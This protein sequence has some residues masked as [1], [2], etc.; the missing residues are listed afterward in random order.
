MQLVKSRRCCVYVYVQH[1]IYVYAINVYAIHVAPPKKTSVPITS[2]S[3]ATAPAIGLSFFS[4][5]MMFVCLSPC[6]L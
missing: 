2:P 1:H 6:F 3:Y 5:E 4:F